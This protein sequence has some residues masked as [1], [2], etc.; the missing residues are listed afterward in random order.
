[1]VVNTMPSVSSFELQLEKSDQGGYKR[2]IYNPETINPTPEAKSI[3]SDK[4]IMLN[5]KASFKDSLAAGTFA[6]Y[7][8]TNHVI[9]DDADM[10][11]I[12]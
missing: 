9:G 10:E 1:M 7:V 6:I 11:I 2:Y 8:S 3:P 5:G 4:T 12:D